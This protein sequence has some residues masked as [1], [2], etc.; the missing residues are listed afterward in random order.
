MHGRYL[1]SGG[2]PYGNVETN[3]M[4]VKTP[5]AYVYGGCIMMHV[6]VFFVS[7]ILINRFER[8]TLRATYYCGL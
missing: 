2:T 3:L 1:F 6:F 7:S 5:T 8:V 4:A